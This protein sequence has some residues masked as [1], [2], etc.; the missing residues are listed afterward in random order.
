L[1]KGGIY[2]STEL[3]KNAENIFL[4]LFT[5]FFCSKKVLFPI[6]SITKADV[7][8]LTELAEKGHYKPVIDRIYNLEQIVEAYRY[9]DTGQKT[10][11]VVIE[12]ID[13]SG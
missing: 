2:I 9:V 6:P 7:G 1:K 12:I 10:G 8:F 11:N 5:P 4:A 13:K 3:G